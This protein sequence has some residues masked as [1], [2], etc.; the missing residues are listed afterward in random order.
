[1]IPLS[2]IYTSLNVTQHNE[3]SIFTMNDVACQ[4]TFL[5]LTKENQN[6]LD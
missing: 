5:T 4:N 6:F 3:R 1:M 2:F